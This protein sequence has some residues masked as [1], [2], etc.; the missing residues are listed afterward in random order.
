MITNITL[1][2]FKCFRQVS[3]NPKLLTVLIGPNGTGKSS[4]LQALLLLKQSGSGNELRYDGS[5]VNLV[6]PA[7]VA[8]NFVE[9]TPEAKLTFDSD[10]QQQTTE[11]LEMLR[12]V[13]AARGLTKVSYAL[14]DRVLE[15]I[16]TQKGLGH[17][18]EKVPTNLAYRRDAEEALS[19]MLKRVTG[20][21]LQV[22]LIPDKQVSVRSVTPY[23]PI[24]IVSE[25]FGANALTQLL[26]QLIIAYRG[27]T[28]LIEEPEIHLH[29]KAQADL[30]EVLAETAKAEDKQIIMT[31]HSEY[32]AGRLL[33]LVAEGRLTTDD[34]AIYSFEKDERG[35]CFATEI[36]VTER[37]QTKGGLTGFDEAT[38]DEMRRYADGLRKHT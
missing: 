21:G 18:E 17:Q 31:T 24:N 22:E 2:N 13:P 28:V 4:I 10:H 25:G 32:I 37:G 23:G 19:K 14:D 12:C 11:T 26:H 33:T 29:P 9:E 5:S 38:R 15:Q 27:A 35:E 6:G 30:A 8:P 3:I 7:A 36:E 34:L 16:P 20:I 1:E